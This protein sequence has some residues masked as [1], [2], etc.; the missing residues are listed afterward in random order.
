[1]M[2]IVVLA[3]SFGLYQLIA[4][5]RKNVRSSQLRRGKKYGF[6]GDSISN[7]YTEDV[8]GILRHPVTF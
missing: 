7:T 2:G 5:S 4:P 3:F 6:M 1:M 8:C